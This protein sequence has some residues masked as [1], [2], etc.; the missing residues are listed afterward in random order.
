MYVITEQGE[1]LQTMLENVKLNTEQGHYLRAADSLRK[2]LNYRTLQ[3]ARL[4]KREATEAQT[5][6]MELK[7]QLA[8]KVKESQA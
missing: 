2:A 6:A 1:V 7:D 3:S 5:W 4:H 8:A